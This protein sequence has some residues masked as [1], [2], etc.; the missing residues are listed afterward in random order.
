MKK[1][2]F[3]A[4]MN[5]PSKPK[6][7]ITAVAPIVCVKSPD[8]IEPQINS[9]MCDE[10]ECEL[11]RLDIG[12]MKAD[13]DNW[14]AIFKECQLR[15]KH[16]IIMYEKAA[17][18][19]LKLMEDSKV[20]A[21]VI[22]EGKGIYVT[23]SY[24]PTDYVYINVS[25]NKGLRCFT[26]LKALDWVQQKIIDLKTSSRKIEN[27]QQFVNAQREKI[28]SIEK[29]LVKKEKFLSH[30]KI[31]VEKLNQ[32]KTNFMEKPEPFLETKKDFER[33]FTEFMAEVE[34]DNALLSHM[35]ED[36][37]NLLNK[38]STFRSERLSDSIVNRVRREINELLSKLGE[39]KTQDEISKIDSA[40]TMININLTQ[41]SSVKIDSTGNA[42][43]QKYSVE[44]MIR[45]ESEFIKTMKKMSIKIN[46]TKKDLK[47]ND[48][49]ENNSV[50]I[51][52]NNNSSIEVDSTKNDS[53]I[54]K[55]S[56]IGL[57]MNKDQSA[58]KVQKVQTKSIKTKPIQ[59]DLSKMD[60][61]ENNS[62]KM[63]LNR[64]RDQSTTEVIKNNK[65]QQ[66]SPK[67]MTN[68][69]E[70]GKQQFEY[71]DSQN[72]TPLSEIHQLVDDSILRM[73]DIL[74][75][76]SLDC[77]DRE[78]FNDNDSITDSI[79]NESNKI[80]ISEYTG[81]KEIQLDQK[82]QKIMENYTDNSQSCGY[83]FQKSILNNL[84]EDAEN[85]IAYETPISALQEIGNISPQEMTGLSECN[86]DDTKSDGYFTK[87][88]NKN[89]KNVIACEIGLE[90]DLSPEKIGNLLPD[91]PASKDLSKYVD[92]CLEKMTFLLPDRVLPSGAK[93]KDFPL[94]NEEGTDDD[95]TITNNSKHFNNEVF[96]NFPSTGNQDNS[97]DELTITK[98]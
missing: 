97:D 21:N 91:M 60:S 55:P 14:E 43:S 36:I 67:Y 76:R 32:M 2:I 31:A 7:I 81:T 22:N 28:N 88:R 89:K 95:I 37:L 13:Y 93:S 83:S 69:T 51:K 33:E 70:V 82:S 77:T 12:L 87:R 73:T 4:K 50:K 92:A 59:N 86:F 6:E 98:F 10:Y 45:N 40:E 24:K 58:I 61:S 62:G 26:P 44:N 35:T 53:M 54:A 29:Y 63:S 15:V 20:E 90:R 57:E 74:S 5:L 49:S 47:K 75:L 11:L 72:K 56:E 85:V 30:R 25:N 18:V 78:E 64:S 46:S 71:D 38:L 48:V 52:S 42:S 94:V 1:Y 8:K 16:E 84:N 96:D 19:I 23:I 34:K 41:N 9:S 17:E 66:L 65:D 3:P 80:E 39:Q 79:E 27:D 68:Y